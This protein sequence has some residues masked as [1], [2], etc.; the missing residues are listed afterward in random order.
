MGFIKE[1]REEMKEKF[2]MNK[3]IIIGFGILI[4][5]ILCLVGYIIYERISQ[6]AYQ[7]GITDGQILI[8][9]QIQQGK[10]PIVT[11]QNNQ[12]Q[13]SWIPIQQICGGGG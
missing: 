2:K 4:I 9:Q 8:I 13:I 5:I 3:R 7:Q 11:N 12:T 10:I 6:R 1:V